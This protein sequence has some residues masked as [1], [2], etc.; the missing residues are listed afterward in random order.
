MRATSFTR[1]DCIVGPKRR[2]YNTLRREWRC[3]LCGGRLGDKWTKA[4]ET[5]PECWHVECLRCGSLNFIHER[6]LERQRAEAAEVLDG[7]STE[8][9]AT[10]GY[11]AKDPNQEPVLFS[12]AP[13][14]AE[15]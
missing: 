10:L 4:S 14:E 13:L 11:E 9:A 2:T 12:L 5:Y 15:I 8:F 6:E 1:H 7:L 3:A